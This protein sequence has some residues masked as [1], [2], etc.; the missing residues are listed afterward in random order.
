M[1]RNRDT[2]RQSLVSCLETSGRAL[3]YKELSAMLGVSEKE[4]PQHME[5][6]AKSLR[7]KGRQLTILPATCITCGYT[8]EKR[9][10]L[11]Q[12]SRCPLCKSERID[13]PLFKLE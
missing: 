1:S 12:P 6:V 7:S 4:L 11:T 3:S 2:L 13:P 9:K 8:F 5:H 10:K